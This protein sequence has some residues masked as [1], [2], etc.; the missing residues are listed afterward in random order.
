MD[1]HHFGAAIL[2]RKRA[3]LVQALHLGMFGLKGILHFGLLIG[4]E[5]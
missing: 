3:V 5:R 4:R 2:L 1:V